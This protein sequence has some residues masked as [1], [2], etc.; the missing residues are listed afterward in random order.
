MPLPVSVFL[1]LSSWAPRTSPF[2]GTRIFFKNGHWEFHVIED[3]S[4]WLLSNYILFFLE[5][6][7]LLVS[8]IV[9]FIAGEIKWTSGQDRDTQNIATVKAIRCMNP[10]EGWKPLG[11]IAHEGVCHSDLRL[12]PRFQ[13]NV[14]VNTSSTFSILV[15]RPFIAS[16]FISFVSLVPGPPL[17][18]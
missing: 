12:H 9:K 11:T 7:C 4:E 14:F 13:H 15:W 10:S 8:D 3:L 1:P 17:T 6:E 2:K 5:K 18:N 16:G